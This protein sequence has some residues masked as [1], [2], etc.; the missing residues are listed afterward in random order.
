MTRTV[1]TISATATAAEAARRIASEH[2]GCLVVIDR[3]GK[4]VGMLTDRDLA[5][6]VIADSRAAEQTPVASIMSA[7]LITAGPDDSADAILT[8]M[9]QHGIRRVPV[10]EDGEVVRI[11]ALDDLLFE[12]GREIDDLGIAVL[13]EFDYAQKAA[14]LDKLRH[15][16]REK[17]NELGRWVED[18]RR[19]LA[20]E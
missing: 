6:R 3:K 20:G 19:S 16:A 18:L 13:S 12:L 1:Q 9:E 15:F 4:A 8:R 17:V 14:S 5:I 2:I 7:P 10:V 11:T